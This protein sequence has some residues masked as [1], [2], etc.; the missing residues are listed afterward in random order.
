MAE[1]KELSEGC[2]RF[3]D[4]SKEKLLGKYKIISAASFKIIKF[5][6]DGNYFFAVDLKNAVFLIKIESYN[7]LL[8]QIHQI[9][10][11]DSDIINFELSPLDPY[12][13]F[14]VNLANVEL[15]I[16]N[17]KFTNVLRNLNYD[18]SI[19]QFNLMDKF[20]L[21]TYFK[22]EF[23]NNNSNNKAN[24]SSYNYN[25]N[26]NINIKLIKDGKELRNKVYD[27]LNSNSYNNNNNI[28]NFKDENFGIG[29]IEFFLINFCFRNK[30]YVYILSHA[31]KYLTI[32]DFEKHVNLINLPLLKNP[33]SFSIS[34]NYGYIVILFRGK[35]FILFSF[36]GFLFKF[37]FRLL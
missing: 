22:N 16:F 32:R 13:R 31:R 7:P 30:N 10:K 9:I 8:L 20:D 33:I 15:H 4:I 36:I 6:P 28:K 18:S 19:P 1:Y 34:P 25:N 17:R 35:I 21:N 26:S 23:E 2:I 11:F 29:A 3:F 5:L 27:K 14:L 24:D 37:K 12:S